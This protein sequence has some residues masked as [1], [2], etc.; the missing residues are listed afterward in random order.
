MSPRSA[1]PLWLVRCAFAGG[2]LGCLVN[3]PLGHSSPPGDAPDIP[4]L[5][6]RLGD[7]DPKVRDEAAK[8]LAGR[9]DAIPALR[10]AL[11]SDDREVARL[12]EAVLNDLKDKRRESALRQI[13]AYRK[14]GHY[15]LLAEVLVRWE[16]E[17]L[18]ADWWEA[19]VGA[20]WD[21]VEAEAATYKRTGL[22]EK[23]DADRGPDWGSFARFSSVPYYKAYP[24]GRPALVIPPKVKEN[25]PIRAACRAEELKALNPDRFLAG[26]VG[27][28]AVT[29]KVNMSNPGHAFLACGGS[30]QFGRCS[31]SVIICGGDC[32]VDDDGAVNSIIVARRNVLVKKGVVHCVILAGGD[33]DVSDLHVNNSTIRAA[34]KIKVGPPNSIIKSEVHPEDPKALAGIRFFELADLGLAASLVEKRMR[35]DRLAADSPLARAGLREGDRIDAVGP[36]TPTDDETLRRA[37]RRAFAERRTTLKIQRDGQPREITVRFPD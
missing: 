19:F 16:D 7:D 13:K 36:E 2:L 24:V 8:L 20:G 33:V 31:Y 12:A 30:V 27:V 11:K 4:T 29:A 15:D 3:I 28:A 10:L 5:I 22:K 26:W 37:L 6:R 32:V 21:L 25:E 18:S 34:G 35:V 17:E 9:E 14:S 1:V 23:A